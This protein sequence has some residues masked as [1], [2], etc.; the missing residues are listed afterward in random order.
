VVLDNRAEIQRR[1]AENNQNFPRDPGESSGCTLARP[2]PA[3]GGAHWL[4]LLAAC[5]VRL[6]RRARRG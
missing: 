2:A 1:I 3:A 4:A 6:G 5:L